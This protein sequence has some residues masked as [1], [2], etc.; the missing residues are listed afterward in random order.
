MLEGVQVHR[1][2]QRHPAQR[3]RAVGGRTEA[4]SVARD[5]GQEEAEQSAEEG[6]SWVEDVAVAA[7]SQGVT[8]KDVSARLQVQI[9]RE[10]ARAL[11][12]AVGALFIDLAFLIFP[13]SLFVFFIDCGQSCRVQPVNL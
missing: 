9:L 1:D 4:D 7:H 2:V 10:P 13:A 5:P 11:S 12:A 8:A 6:H 3:R